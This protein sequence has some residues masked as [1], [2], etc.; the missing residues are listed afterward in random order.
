MYRSTL[1]VVLKQSHESN[2]SNGSELLTSGEESSEIESGKTTSNSS[3]ES[4]ET[5][6]ENSDH[7]GNFLTFLLE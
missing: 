6:N 1:K 5:S 7:I 2:S 4:T 3:R